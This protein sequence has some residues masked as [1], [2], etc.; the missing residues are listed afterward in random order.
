MGQVDRVNESRL[1]PIESVIAGLLVGGSDG[2]TAMVRK[3]TT[4]AECAS[5]D[6]SNDEVAED[7][8]Q[9]RGRRVNARV[10]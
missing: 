1:L 7:H 6:V 10:Q 5:R 3:S 2:A 9:I 4:F 8:N